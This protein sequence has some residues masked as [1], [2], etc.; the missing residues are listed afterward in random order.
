MS[1]DFLPEHEITGEFPQTIGES[2]SAIHDGCSTSAKVTITKTKLGHVWYCH[3]CARAGFARD[4]HVYGNR[5]EA[6]T[7]SAHVLKSPSPLDPRVRF[8]PLV[9]TDE[10]A[11]WLRQFYTHGEPLW[12]TPI[13]GLSLHTL[14]SP[15]G[16]KDQLA[17]LMKSPILDP[18]HPVEM[19]QV[20]RFDNNPPKWRLFKH[21]E[22]PKLPWVARTGLTSTGKYPLVLVEDV[23]SAMALYLEA[24]RA[25]M[26]WGVGC[27]NGLSLPFEAA[28]RLSSD[29]D[30]LVVVTDVDDA[31]LKEGTLLVS[32]LLPLFNGK[33]KARAAGQPS[34]KNLTQPE[35]AVLVQML[36][37]DF[38][39]WT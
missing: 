34:P 31:G 1:H 11:M 6:T 35:M 39:A 25:G 13:T 10:G 22:G 7:H 9:D 38:R 36:D 2:K 19:T 8:R 33:V 30:S 32:E 15:S 12:N 37:M 4:R 26:V 23:V 17:F 20:R 24:R 27:M 3:K 29:Y 14:Q 16:G 5:V 18:A 21:Y 28:V